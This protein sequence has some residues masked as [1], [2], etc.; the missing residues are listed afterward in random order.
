M[1]KV[2]DFVISWANGKILSGVT[3]PA[4]RAQ[5]KKFVLEYEELEAKI[6]QLNKDR[7][8]SD[9]KVD[10]LQNKLYEAVKYLEEGKRRFAPHTTNSFV[11]EFITDSKKV[12]C[13]GC[14]Q[15]WPDKQSYDNHN[16]KKDQDS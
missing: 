3:S 11:D 4:D 13:K 8:K 7:Y 1:S 5:L 10:Q 15:N 14:N 9:I 12:Y 6:H 16:C 2:K